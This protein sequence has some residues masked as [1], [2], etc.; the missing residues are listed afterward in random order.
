MAS[1]DAG[2]VAPFDAVDASDAV[3]VIDAPD[4]VDAAEAPDTP[5]T[6]AAAD[7]AD[8][9]AAIDVPMDAV[10]APA[11]AVDA[12]VVTDVPTLYDRPAPADLPASP[13][14]PRSHPLTTAADVVELFSLHE[15]GASSAR[16]VLSRVHESSDGVC[17]PALVRADRRYTGDAAGPCG[18][19]RGAFTVTLGG[20]WHH[21][22]TDPCV[23]TN[24]PKV[25]DLATHAVSLQGNDGTEAVSLGFD[26]TAHMSSERGRSEYG[27]DGTSR[28]TEVPSSWLPST[29]TILLGRTVRGVSVT[30]AGTD[31][32]GYT[33]D[34]WVGTT[35][36][37]RDGGT[38]VGA[39]F[40]TLEPVRFDAIPTCFQPT[41]G[42][43]LLHG[44]AEVEIRFASGASCAT[45]TWTR[46]GVPMGPITLVY[47][48]YVTLC[49][50]A[51]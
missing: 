45:P 50:A 39:L 41:A 5:D 9:P 8:V 44:A 6:P 49:G 10:D 38:E 47:W 51:M 14:T 46:D 4:A 21:D 30:R 11:S 34:G 7:V 16:I 29:R 48:G 23:D 33:Y 27:W 18:G 32:A 22:W 19:S 42:R 26:G 36:P 1:F 24:G 28:W 31:A 40:E 43:I 3:D 25:Y 35:D 13:L 20:S 37:S 17:P 12:P 15:L 2:A